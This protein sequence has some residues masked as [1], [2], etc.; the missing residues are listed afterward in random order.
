MNY[1]H[2]TQIS[3]NKKTGP[4]AV[5]TSPKKTCPPECPLI[6]DGCFA[7]SGPLNLHWLKV[8]DNNRGV[9]FDDF[10]L[11]VGALP[12][13]AEYRHN[14][15]GDLPGQDGQIDA[16]KLNKLAKTTKKR[17]LRAFTYSHYNV[18][19]NI[20]NRLAIQAA[21]KDGFIINLSANNIA[22][23][24]TLLNLKIA[25]VAVIMPL[26]SKKVSYT[27][28]GN[29]IVICPAQTNK[30][31]TCKVCMLCANGARDF[32]IGFLPHG[33]GAKKAALATN[34]LG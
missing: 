3:A 12:M 25:P 6:N 5:S 11:Q 19:T 1:Y 28:K 20:N 15:A 10:L 2:L 9:P 13:R 21:N 14:Q 33:T 29:K 16:P 34:N 8:S 22:E 23:V 27:E 17:K 26:S 7:A 24:D 31:T 18:L 32:T 30:H 4:I